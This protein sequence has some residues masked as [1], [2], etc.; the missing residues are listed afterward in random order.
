MEQLVLQLGCSSAHMAMFDA[1][2]G[3]L[4]HRQSTASEDLFLPWPPGLLGMMEEDVI[5]QEIRNIH[6]FDQRL[7]EHFVKIFKKKH[8]KDIQ[9]DPRAMQKLKSE[10]EKAKRDLSNVH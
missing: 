8:G 6:D 1:A 2:E 9:S 3:F 10:V 4:K 7:S 5:H